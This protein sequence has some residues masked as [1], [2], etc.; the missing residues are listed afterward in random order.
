MYVV[1][2]IES[3]FGLACDIHV[4]INVMM[5]DINSLFPCPGPLNRH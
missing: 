1:I 3:F 5:R 2:D 4:N